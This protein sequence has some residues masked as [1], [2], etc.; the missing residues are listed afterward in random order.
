MVVNDDI[1][2]LDA[3]LCAQCHETE[4]TWSGAH[5]IDFS[6]F[7]SALAHAVSLARFFATILLPIGR[8]GSKRPRLQLVAATAI[9]LR[10]LARAVSSFRCS[11]PRVRRLENCNRR[12]V[13]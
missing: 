12:A 10:T 13:G 11:S 7:A 4:I 6:V 9:H 5:Q 3:F 2:V 1:G 8:L